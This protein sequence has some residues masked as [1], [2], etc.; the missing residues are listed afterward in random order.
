MKRMVNFKF[1]VLACLMAMLA[2]SCTDLEI[3]QTDSIIDA[4]GSDGGTFS[5]VSAVDASVQDLYNGTYGQLGDQANFFAL[6]EVS[7]DETLVPTRGTDWSDNGIWRT[8]HAHTWAPTHQYILTVWNQL[9]Q[10]VFRASEIIDPASTGLS[11][12]ATLTLEE[13]KAEAHFLRAF[14][15]FFVLD[16]WGIAPFRGVNDGADVDPA[17]LSSQEAYALILSDLD[18][19]IAGLPSFGPSSG[20]N[21]ASVAAAK[22]LKAKLLLNSGRY[23]TEGYP[24]TDAADPSSADLQMVIDLVDDIAAEGFALQGGYFDLF[25]ED[26]DNETIWWANTAVGNRI[27]NGLH[28]NTV[29]PDNT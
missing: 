15:M 29:A 17:V 14:S 1:K 21:R 22:F 13:Y 27:W 5:G 8:L 7:T 3:E 6:N 26:V 9:N 20:T 16:F 4:G 11:E 10:N 18:A 2:V 19:A 23:L 28:Y 25:K 24:Q 12:S